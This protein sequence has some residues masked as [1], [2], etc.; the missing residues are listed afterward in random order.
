[1]SV[2]VFGI[3]A[4]TEAAPTGIRSINPRPT[5]NRLT[6]ISGSGHYR[7]AVGDSGTVV[8]SVDDGTTWSDGVSGA[9]ADLKAVW[10]SSERDVWA[11]G[12]EGTILQSTDG[13]VQWRKVGPVSVGLNGVW[14]SSADDVYIV[15]D[16]G[17]LLH[18]R[19]GGQSF[20]DQRPLG[21][22]DEA[23]T[24]VW[25]NGREDVYVGGDRGSLL[26]S[27]DGGA[28]WQVRW[29]QTPRRMQ[30]PMTAP[31]KGMIVRLLAGGGRGHLLAEVVSW[32]RTSKG[33]AASAALA[34]TTDGGLS[35]Q[36]NTRFTPPESRSGNLGPF[37]A[38]D[39]RTIYGAGTFDVGRGRKV[40]G[41][42][43]SHDAG[44]TFDRLSVFEIPT[45]EGLWHDARGSWIAVGAGGTILRSTDDGR[46]W[47]EQSSHPLGKSD[48]QAIWATG[49]VVWIVGGHCTALRSSDAG[50]TFTI[51]RPCP[52]GKDDAFV[53]V[54]GSGPEDVYLAG[55]DVVHT[56]DRG[57]HFS[58]VTPPVP[59]TSPRWSVWGSD[60]RNVYLSG[61][62]VWRST[63]GA[64]SWRAVR[65]VPSDGKCQMTGDVFGAGP[66]DV[67]VQA[68]MDLLHST[69]NG[70]NWSLFQGPGR[71]YRF[72]QTAP[73]VVFAFGTDNRILRSV[74]QGRSWQGLSSPL[75]AHTVFVA[76]A[77]RKD[78]LFLLGSEASGTEM[79]SVVVR[80]NDGGTTWH[81]GPLLP[82][83]MRAIA[84]TPDGGELV[85]GW[86]GLVQATR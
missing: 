52:P 14:G 73:A 64:R 13:G 85:A 75:D 84:I 1:M 10:A 54:W 38:V 63:D 6:A 55:G 62:G 80:S 33:S 47:R 68:G 31:A 48:L 3:A 65:S 42:V 83:G 56:T 27:V 8:R 67:Y 45:I 35:W 57:Q 17:H 70:A 66:H 43:V 58:I 25:G 40:Q 86:R 46:S 41:F 60:A 20:Q 50:A 39:A 9:A 69:T 37:F 34:R 30:G 7:W 32:V 71:A 4:R 51:I 76:M 44:A 74:D 29:P 21:D 19:N 5:G 26:A 72:W 11:V 22:T 53:S 79:R 81:A 77:G 59:E 18:T 12:G 82:W 15:G 49:S 24:C 36:F 16:R 2:F 28:H 23:F 78:D 61:C